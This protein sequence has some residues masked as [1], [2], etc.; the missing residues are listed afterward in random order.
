VGGP[1]NGVELEKM[2]HFSLRPPKTQNANW[3]KAA[4][5]AKHMFIN[6]RAYIAFE[7]CSYATLCF[8]ISIRYVHSDNG[9]QWRMNNGVWTMD[10]KDTGHWTQ[11]AGQCTLIRAMVRTC[12]DKK[13][14]KKNCI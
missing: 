14:I 2:L 9:K 1:L 10:K 3:P 6:L 8:C 7:G 12:L 4:Q 11:D 5:M 13:R